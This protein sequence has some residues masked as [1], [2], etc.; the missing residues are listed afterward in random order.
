MDA[1]SETGDERDSQWPGADDTTARPD[2]D[3]GA[4]SA[5]PERGA[6]TGES[7]NAAVDR[8][9]EDGPPGQES[10]PTADG[11]DDRERTPAVR[12]R[13]ADETEETETLVPSGP[14]EPEDIDTENAAFVLLGVLLVVGLILAAILGL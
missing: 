3:E 5:T 13:D 14:L 12:R 7:R 1:G 9:A 11:F 10:G 2:P 4:G 8:N 6:A